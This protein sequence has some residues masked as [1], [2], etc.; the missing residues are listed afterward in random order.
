MLSLLQAT[1]VRHLLLDSAVPGLADAAGKVGLVVVE[2]Q[3]VPHGVTVVKGPWPGIRV[4]HSGGDRASAGPTGE[5]WVDSNGWRIKTARAQHPGGPIWVD[6]KP[7]PSRS[8]KEDYTLAFADAA[9][10]GAQWIIG[11]DDELAAG[12]AAKKPEAMATWQRIVQGAAFF[13]IDPAGYND[14]AVIGVLSTFSGPR[15]FTDEVLNNLART[16]QQYRAIAAQSMTPASLSGLKGIIY[17]DAAEPPADVRK[18]V[19]DFV[20]SGGMLITG[21]AWGSLPKGEAQQS[22][23][24]FS[25]RKTGNGAIAIGGTFS[26]PYRVPNDAVV[27]VSHRHDIVRFFNSGAITPCLAASAD[28]RRTTLHTVFYS[29]RPVEDTS[30]WVKGSYRAARIRTWSQPQSQNVRLEKRDT[31]IEIHLPAVAQYAMIE[32]ES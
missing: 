23:P 22:H 1:P 29:L 10:H 9:A 21:S 26:D 32:L 25:V 11:L 12:V 30:V 6:A 18:L 15:S 13:A 3:A 4:S 2:P 8:S 5:P 28:K 27:L 20:N 31:G 16:R 17:T 14:Q 24:R 7:Q 19:L